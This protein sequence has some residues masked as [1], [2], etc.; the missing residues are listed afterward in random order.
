MR[1][2]ARQPSLADAEQAPGLRADE[3]DF[4]EEFLSTRQEFLERVPEFRLTATNA[5]M[6]RDGACGIS[7]ARRSS[8]ELIPQVTPT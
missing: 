1:L 6:I 4:T 8:T 2:H 7:I 3:V 5:S